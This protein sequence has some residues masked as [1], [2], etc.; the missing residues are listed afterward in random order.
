MDW[1]KCYKGA[2]VVLISLWLRMV[3]EELNQQVGGCQYETRE[4]LI[5]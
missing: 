5:I 3:L 4:L 1:F 2:F